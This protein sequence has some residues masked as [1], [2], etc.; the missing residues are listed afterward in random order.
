[1]ALMLA[2]FV[3][4]AVLAVQVFRHEAQV[5]QYVVVQYYVMVLIVC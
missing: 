2:A 5:F 1:M 4:F 3:V